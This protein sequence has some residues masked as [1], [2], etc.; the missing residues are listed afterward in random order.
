[1]QPTR[2]PIAAARRIAEHAA[3][4]VRLN[5]ELRT[6]DLKPRATKIGIGLGLG[7]VALLLSPLLVLFLL[8]AA[9]AALATVVQVWL[10]ILI[11]AAGLFL[12]VG[13]LAAAAFI[14]GSKGVKGDEDGKL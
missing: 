2:N 9:T 4:L 10:A 14:V 1:M 3:N 7:I 5:V 6:V 13:G 11:V 12:I 8:A